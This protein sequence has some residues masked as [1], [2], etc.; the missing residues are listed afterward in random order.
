MIAGDHYRFLIKY[1]EKD[2]SHHLL[3]KAFTKKIKDHNKQEQKEKERLLNLVPEMQAE[4]ER[5][6]KELSSKDDELSR[7]AEDSQMLKDLY[8]QG[9]IDESGNPL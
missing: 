4:I 1:S 2:R 8:S 9:I 3:R 7:F 5:L 6:K